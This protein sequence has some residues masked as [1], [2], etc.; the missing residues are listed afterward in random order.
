MVTEDQRDVVAL[1]LRPGTHGPAC[2]AVEQI[3]THSAMVFLAGDRA[4]KLKRA[5]RYD[6]LD[7]STVER[8]RQCCE[9]EVALNRRLAPALYRGVV[10]VTLEP[11]GTLALA[12]AGTPV[13]WLVDMTR[14]DGAALADRL[15]EAGKLPLDHMPGLAGTVARFHMNAEWR[16]DHG[17]AVGIRWVV[18]G[19][20][21]AF[22]EFGEALGAAAARTRLA[23]D[24][25]RVLD[26]VAATLDRRQRAGLV[27]QCHGDLHLGNIVLLDGTLTPFDAVEFNDDISCIDVGYDLAFLLMDLCHRALPRHANLVLNEY[28]R[29]TGDLDS[30]ALL[31]L[32]LSCRAAV[33][34]KTNATAATLAAA[35]ERLVLLEAARQYLDLAQ[36]F[37]AP[38]APV[39][40]A[41]GGLSGAGKSTA[42]ALVAPLVGPAPGALHLRTD[43]IRKALCGVAPLDRLP[44]DAYA[45]DVTARV[46]E[47][48]RRDA[49][50]AL[51]AGHAVVCDGVFGAAAERRALAD[52]SGRAGVPLVAL[53]LDA[54]EATLLARVERRRDDA[55]DATAEVVRSQ[56]AHTPPPADWTRVDAS[57]AAEV[58]AARVIS[59]LTAR[60]VPCR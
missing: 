52:V 55:S 40:V 57:G 31:P 10:A 12:G 19:N 50:T 17:G 29:N 6:Y 34:A 44:G 54:P 51:A 9:A 33:R 14:F 20:R 21:A 11:D 48:I 58:T 46:Y 45:A 53:W 56:V 59:L 39:L 38:P 13:E 16:L 60:G 43:V 49:G 25:A 7:F 3:E 23:D 26:A 18:E 8:R 5:V 27:R 28:L 2:H 32:F 35:P 4:L 22:V 47:R 15:A 1:L 37:L 41:I 30:L 36:A 42:A 24:A